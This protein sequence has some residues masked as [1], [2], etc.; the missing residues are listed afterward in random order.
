MS[1]LKDYALHNL[2]KVRQS[3]KNKKI[4]KDFLIENLC[5]YCHRNLFISGD[6]NKLVIAV[7]PSCERLWKIINT[8][9]I[10]G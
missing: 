9:G 3:I 7:C 6:I 1:K 5:P 4:A 8:K 10:N 2:D